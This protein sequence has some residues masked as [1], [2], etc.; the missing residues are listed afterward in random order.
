MTDKYAVFGNP[1]AHSLSPIIHTFFAKTLNEDLEYSRI[2]V[3]DHKFKETA[4]AFKES[5]GKGFNVTVPCK[6]DA[7]NFVDFLSEDAKIAGAV[8]TV[9]FTQEGIYGF[10]TDGIGFV[11][12]LK[13]LKAKVSGAKVLLLG[14]GGA[15]QGILNPLLK[16]GVQSITIVNRTQSKADALVEKFAS[17]K[18]KTQSMNALNDDFSII[19]N[20]TASSLHN[21]IPPLSDELIKNADFIYDVMYSK[22][23]STVFTEKAQALGV[24]K[25]YDGIGMLIMQAAASFEIWRGK[26]PDVEATIEYFRSTLA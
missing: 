18:I 25:A 1:I 9:K 26:Q 17:S 24:T 22:K 20:A 5:G 4:L 23:G 21:E 6:I 8:N 14:A 3:E 10:N 19:I 15:A 13:R 11:S 16:E 12:D 2:L 7:F